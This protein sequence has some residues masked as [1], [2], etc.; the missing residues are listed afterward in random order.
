MRPLRTLL[1]HPAFH[2]SVITLLLLSVLL[3]S[4]IIPQDDAFLYKQFIETLATGR[5]DLSIAGF[6][7]ASFLTLPLYL[8]T[9][10]PLA[11]E[12]FQM[13][14]GLCIPIAGF[15]AAHALLQ[16]K[17]QA[18]FFAYALALMP[19][20]QFIALRGFTFPSFTLFLLLTL[21]LRARGSRWAFLA[22]G[23]SLLIKP[24]S[25]ALLPLFLWWQPST[26]TP[27]TGMRRG[28]VQLL[29]G[30]SIAAAYVLAQYSQIGR[31]IVGAHTEID[32]TNVFL[33]SRFPLN[34]LH[35]IQMMFS[36]HNFYFVD[37][38]R[39]GMGNMTHSSPLL[40]L[41]GCIAFLYPKDLWKDTR[42]ARALGL[43]ALL[44]FFLAAALDHM[45]HFYMETCVI[46]LTLG[47]IPFLARHLLLL[48]LVL[49]TLHFQFFYLH[50][51]WKDLYFPDSSL[52]IIPLAI[53]VLAILA[54][55]VF[56]ASHVRWQQILHW[57]LH[58][59]KRE[60]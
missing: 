59:A 45:D 8:L 28:W 19:F 13:F 7:G 42:L 43:S 55:A 2:L 9:G 38:A 36:V 32:Q 60:P 50:L 24:F 4:N 34:V 56:R 31:V 29:L 12:W 33:L 58:T 51:M 54:W 48:P 20:L 22:L 1:A 27:H 57:F 10:S 40:M 44:A 18:I 6:H 46:L 30:V 26:T 15:F 5:I 16:D 41:M 53:D 47:A 21:L 23:I 39:T 3:R 35:G 11:H 17:T 52:W 49:I 14:C 37:P 25:I